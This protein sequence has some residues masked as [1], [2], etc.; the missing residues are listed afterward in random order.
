MG[1]DGSMVLKKATDEDFAQAHNS[2]CQ[3]LRDPSCFFAVFE[4]PEEGRFL[5]TN[6]GVSKH[7]FAISLTED[8][9][10]GKVRATYDD[11]TITLMHPEKKKLAEA[12]KKIT[13]RWYL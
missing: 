3:L 2:G 4:D 9:I 1:R 12:L 5:I 10:P 13:M 8:I 11:T 7:T 6:Y